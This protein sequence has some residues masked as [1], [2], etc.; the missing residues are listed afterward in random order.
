MG[1]VSV[2]TEKSIL[3][4]NEQKR[5]A[6]KFGP[7]EV[8]MVETPIRGGVSKNFLPFRKSQCQLNVGSDEF[9]QHP[10]GDRI[11]L[12]HIVAAFDLVPYL[13]DFFYPDIL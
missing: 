8:F 1:F 11:G 12:N 9:V 13:F 10:P 5:A 2:L 4:P 6:Q 7:P 3:L